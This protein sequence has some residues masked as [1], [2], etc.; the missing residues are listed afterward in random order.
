MNH[1]D[2][3]RDHEPTDGRPS[4]DAAVEVVT[5]PTTLIRVTGVLR[6]V[7]RE[8]RGAP[9]DDAGRHRMRVLLRSCLR[10]LDECLD[11]SLRGE[12][13]RVMERVDLSATT[14]DAELRIVEATLVGWLEGL[15]TSVE[16]VWSAQQIAAGLRNQPDGE[17]DALLA[18]E[19]RS[20]TSGSRRSTTNAQAY[21]GLYL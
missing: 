9:L 13:R 2:E 14:T 10:E 11:P 21:P 18:P 15:L 1:L 19:P 6:R 20:R 7:L 17:R 12:L 16:P 8:L 5:A 3:E 4:Q